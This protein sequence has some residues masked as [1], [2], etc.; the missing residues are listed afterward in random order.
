MS[1]TVIGFYRRSLP[2]ELS[3]YNT[4]ITQLEVSILGFTGV[5]VPVSPTMLVRFS[6]PW[7]LAFQSGFAPSRGLGL[8]FRG[9]GF[10]FQ[11]LGLGV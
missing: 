10:G 11:G 8:G 7:P 4:N 9:L 2:L 1:F 6:A 3:Q 5:A